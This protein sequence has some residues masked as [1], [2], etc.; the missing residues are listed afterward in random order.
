[1]TTTAVPKAGA[2]SEPWWAV[3]VNPT[4]LLST[5]ATV[6]VL[7][8]AVYLPSRTGNLYNTPDETAN[9]LFTKTFAE[10]GKPWYTN[11]LV[12]L[13]EENLIHPRGVLEH[14]GRYVSYQYPTL[15]LVYGALYR[16]FGEAVE[17]IGAVFAAAMLFFL[18]KTAKLL[19]NARYWQIVAL[20][21]G[22]TPLLFQYSRPY[23]AAGAAITFFAGGCWL[24]A[25]YMISSQ[26]RDLL[27]ATAMFVGGM[28]FR[29]EYALFASVLVLAAMWH[30]HQRLTSKRLWLDFATYA[31]MVGLMFLLPVLAVNTLIYDAPLTYGYKIFNDVYLPARGP[32]EGASLFEN[33][34]RAMIEVLLPQGTFDPGLLVRNLARFTLGLMPVL[35]TLALLGA[36]VAVRRHSPRPRYLIAY[37]LVLFY[38]IIYMAGGDTYNATTKFATFD[39]SFVR[40]WLPFGLVLVILAGYALRHFHDPAVQA[41]LAVVLAVYGVASVLTLTHGSL[42]D[43]DASV[44]RYE[45]WA[46][47]VIVPNT[48]PNAVVYVGLADKAI[49]PYRNVAAWWSGTYDRDDVARSMARVSYAGMPVY[50]YKERTLSI[51]DLNEG[52]E[53][54]DLHAISTDGPAL[55]KIVKIDHSRD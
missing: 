27:L 47:E 24:L 14:D 54:Y 53:R 38:I 49:V 41:T 2:L 10:T 3:A 17:Y 50:V 25:R 4:V 40:Y 11:D 5:L 55:Y 28:L 37:G 1:M 43:V 48:E 52:L 29:Y 12:A 19:Y 9:H 32:Q 34:G 7:V 36:V 46:E 35:S 42:T 26:R 33:G 21:M 51:I 39:A 23:M 8:I 6:L 20:C 16:F 45:T 31:S 22:F 30:K 13:D 15:P 18:Y 44:Q